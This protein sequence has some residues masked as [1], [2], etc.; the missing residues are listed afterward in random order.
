MSCENIKI[1]GTF[2]E[3]L[4]P[5]VFNS[6]IIHIKFLLL[7]TFNTSFLSAE[8]KSILSGNNT[9]N[10]TVMKTFNLTI[11]LTYTYLQAGS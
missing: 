10:H 8:A 4:S 3:F 2:S 5:F 11:N 6:L 7:L 9:T 1:I